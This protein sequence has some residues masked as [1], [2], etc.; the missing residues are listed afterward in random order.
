MQGLALGFSEFSAG[1]RLLG[2]PQQGFALGPSG[3]FGGQTRR[4]AFEIG[5]GG[6]KIGGGVLS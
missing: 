6:G 2:E 4:L 5:E 3:Q 1:H